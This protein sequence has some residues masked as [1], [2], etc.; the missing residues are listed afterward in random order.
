MC[1]VW[2]RRVECSS[3][4]DLRGG[5]HAVAIFWSD[6]LRSEFERSCVQ[7]I[8]LVR[9][10]CRYSVMYERCAWKLRYFIAGNALGFHANWNSFS[11]ETN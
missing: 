7:K 11:R 9:S 5:V 6:L 3:V 2:F 10:L 1:L 4:L 8:F